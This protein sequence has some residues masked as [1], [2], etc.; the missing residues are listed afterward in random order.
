MLVL[1][2]FP[3]GGFSLS[4]I[5]FKNA[6]IFFPKKGEILIIF[7]DPQHQLSSANTS[8]LRLIL[9]ANRVHSPFGL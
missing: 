6:Y 3:H 9:R 4:K 7:C 2:T 1:Y 8:E 5:D